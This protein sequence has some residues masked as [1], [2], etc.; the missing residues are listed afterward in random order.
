MGLRLNTGVPDRAFALEHYRRAAA[1]Y[2]TSCHRI[3]RKRL[4][5]LELLALRPGETVID[6]ACGTGPLLETLARKVGPQGSV[7]GIEQSPEMLA[8]AQQRLHRL[9][10]GNVLLIE[11][12]I[13]EARIS[14]A[15]DAMLFC[16]THDVLR[17]HRALKNLFSVAKPGARVSLCGAKLHPRWLAPLNAW[18]RRRVY[19]YSSTVEGLDR[20]WSL[21]ATHCPD[22]AVTD[23]YFWGSGYVGAGTYRQSQHAHRGAGAPE[24]HLSTAN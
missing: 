23:T 9:A 13:E 15:A 11:A 10:L 22:F 3:E 20:P 14:A 24:R 7:I 4:R 1:G 19:G 18:V 21:L 17:S 2:D 5:A 6:V 8:L 16:Y 12:P